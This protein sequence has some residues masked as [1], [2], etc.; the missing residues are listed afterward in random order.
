VEDDF[1]KF[2]D[3]DSGHTIEIGNLSKNHSIMGV[4]VGQEV[5]FFEHAMS[6]RRAF[7]NIY[8]QYSWLKSFAKINKIAMETLLRAVSK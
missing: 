1:V 4:T 3:N 5:D 6:W 2:E 8:N 7:S